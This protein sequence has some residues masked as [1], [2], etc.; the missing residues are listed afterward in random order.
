M[1]AGSR[2]TATIETARKGSRAA[3]VA[4]FCSGDPDMETTRDA[5]LAAVEAGVDMV[6][7]GVPF[8]DPMADGPVIQEASQRALAAGSSL[9]ATLELIAS[10]RAHTD[11][12][13]ILFGYYNPFF[14]YGHER[15][16]ADLASAGG[17]GLLVVD[18]P[19]EEAAP[20]VKALRAS[21]LDRIFMLAPTSDQAR[22]SAVAKVASGFVYFVAVTGVT[23]ERGAAPVGIDT[24]VRTVRDK[25]GLPVGVGFGIS[26][27]EYAREVGGYADLVIV[28]SAVT[29]AM[30]EAGRG[31]AAAAAAGLLGS[32]RRALGGNSGR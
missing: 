22:I 8:S 5:V 11:I 1:A 12:P 4:Y 10:L 3:L 9:P 17:D 32:M 24:L 21:K 15:L 19:P 23:G 30:N 18:L 14:R 2:I 26:R 7:L 20:T 27:P 31:G 16:A 25:A 28:G 6:E 29:R 13:V